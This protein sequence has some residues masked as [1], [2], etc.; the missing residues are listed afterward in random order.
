MLEMI[1]HE[2]SF[3][4]KIKNKNLNLNVSVHLV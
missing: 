2:A 4:Q 1:V 3:F